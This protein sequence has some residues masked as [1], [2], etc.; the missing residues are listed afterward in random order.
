MIKVFFMSLLLTRGAQVFASDCSLD[1]TARSEAGVKLVKM[2][3][4]KFDIVPNTNSHYVISYT[5]EV[6]TWSLGVRAFTEL[7][8]IDRHSNENFDVV[9]TKATSLSSNSRRV[10]IRALKKAIKKLR[11]CK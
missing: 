7:K 10:G 11:T 5:T 4:D 1:I 6:W 9:K 2:L 8:V 3:S